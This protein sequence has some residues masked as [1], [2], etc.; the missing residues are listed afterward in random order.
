[1]GLVPIDNPADPRVAPYRNLK[2]GQSS[3][4]SM[5][6]ESTR[7]VDQLLA[8]NFTCHSILTTVNKSSRFSREIAAGIPVFVASQAVLST[9]VGFDIHRGCLAH[10][11]APLLDLAS[12]LETNSPALTVVMEGLA[13]PANVGAVI[14]NA[15]A[16]GA[17]LVIADP[18]A[19]SPY[20]RKATRASVG[21]V[22]QVPIAV[23]PPV[24]AIAQLRSRVSDLTVIAAT[25]RP[26]APKLC[27]LVTKPHQVLMVGNEGLGLSQVLLES[28]D[29]AGR[30]AMSCGVDSLNVAAATAVALYALTSAKPAFAR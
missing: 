25:S 3:L 14:R 4:E 30:I 9:L 11:S 23:V 28:A 6:V 19:A 20:T 10:A 27:G 18:K 13:D 12:H 24:E 2:S 17:T 5:I 21:H 16:F 22:F 1:M 8:S 7:L 26:S 15:A 29:T